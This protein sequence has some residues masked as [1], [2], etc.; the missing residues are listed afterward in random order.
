[1]TKKNL[2]SMILGTIG[3]V[4]FAIGMCMC[5]LPE[6]N[7]FNQG[8]VVGAVVLITM[9]LARRKM[10]GKPMIQLNLKTIGI[11]LPA[12]I[13]ALAL[14]VGMCLTMLWGHL[15]LGIIVGLIGIVLLLALIPLCKGLKDRDSQTTSTKEFIMAKSPLVKV[16]QK[17]VEKVVGTH[18]AIADAVV[19]GYKTIEDGVGGGTTTG[20]RVIQLAMMAEMQGAADVVLNAPAP[21]S[22]VYDV[23][24]VMNIPI[25][26]TVLACDGELD[27]KINAGA[28]IIN[29]A[30]GRRTPNVVQQIRQ[31][32]PLHPAARQR[33]FDR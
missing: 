7:A 30:A 6:W 18:N 32:P 21:S 20:P 11:A 26:A 23:A 31:R 15:P 19:G 12:L 27:D 28:A 9:L 14:G 13:G 2:V 25:I 3:G 1:M 24:R 33:R 5:M 10:E 8:V 4:L 29:V 16:N 17:V 22:T